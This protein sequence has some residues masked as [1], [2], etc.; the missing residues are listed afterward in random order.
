MEAA[1]RTLSEAYPGRF[2]LGLGTS[3]GPVVEQRG[4][5]YER[6]LEHLRRYLQAMDDAPLPW[7]NPDLERARVLAALGSRMLELA[8]EGSAGAL[9]YHQTPEHT[10]RA[11]EILGT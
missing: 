1:S 7:P 8:G 3:H 11:R 2:L 6:P 5:D 4:H 10:A 9:A